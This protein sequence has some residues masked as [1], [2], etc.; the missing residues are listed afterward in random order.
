MWISSYLGTICWRNCPF[1]HWWSWHPC[2][3]SID[4]RD[5]W[6]YFWTLNS[7]LLIHMST[8]MPV[9]HCFDYY[10]FFKLGSMSSP[11]LFFFFKIVLTIQSPLQFHMNFRINFAICAKKAARILVE[12]VF[13][14]SIVYF[15][16][17]Q[18]LIEELILMSLICS[19]IR[20]SC[21]TG[22]I[23]W[24]HEFSLI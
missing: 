8:L 5:V 17:L 19:L 22:F 24:H 11:A 7:I 14:W 15:H 9:P 13:P 1:P 6:V 16:C 4:Y 21:L 10:I 2:Q 12:I 20:V 18:F 23:E 3:K